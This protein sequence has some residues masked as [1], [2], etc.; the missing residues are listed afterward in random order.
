M[1]GSSVA[2]KQTGVGSRKAIR[3]LGLLL[4]PEPVAA[5]KDAPS[6]AAV[7]DLDQA[8]EH[9]SKV[10][11]IPRLKNSEMLCEFL[12]G[13]PEDLSL[14]EQLPMIVPVTAVAMT[15]AIFDEVM[16]PNKPGV[17]VV[18]TQRLLPVIAR[19][20]SKAFIRSQSPI[21]TPAVLNRCVTLFLPDSWT[22]K[23]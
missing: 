18:R 7:F 13:A 5:T 23:G 8:F 19:C 6:P 4:F 15:R 1:N 9:V 20:T 10:W 17:A 22:Q 14:V 12:S 3:A 11:G 16:L 21:Y 2:V